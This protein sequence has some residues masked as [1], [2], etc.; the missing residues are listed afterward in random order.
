MS[1]ILD[2]PL[3][4]SLTMSFLVVSGEC[5]AYEWREELYVY[6]PCVDSCGNRIDV[7]SAL[8]DDYG[9]DPEIGALIAVE[10]NGR[11][12]HIPDSLLTP[13]ERAAKNMYEQRMRE[14]GYIE[15]LLRGPAG[16][17]LRLEDDGREEA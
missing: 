3:N 11:W 16:R 9:T 5:H 10:Y 15:I 1:N 4:L 7:I 17:C 14:I 12:V 13:M 6:I 8:D 2:R